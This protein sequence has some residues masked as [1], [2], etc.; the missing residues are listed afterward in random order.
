MTLMTESVQVG[1]VVA[2][3]ETDDYGN[4]ITEVQWSEPVPAWLEQTTSLE[5][6]G[7]QA[8]QEQS[9]SIQRLFLELDVPIKH[10]SLVRWRGEEWTVK[11]RPGFQPGGFEV[12]GFRV[13]TLEL[14]ED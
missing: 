1:V 14:V 11:G 9:T 5:N 6:E 3:G 13:A 2:T 10:T 7:T 4:D 8:N 12:P